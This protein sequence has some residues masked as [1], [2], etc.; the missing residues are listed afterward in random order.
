MKN[1]LFVLLLV[2][3]VSAASL[4]AQEGDVVIVEEELKLTSDDEYVSPLDIVLDGDSTTSNNWFRWRSKIGIDLTPNIWIY[5]LPF[6]ANLAA[7]YLGLSAM[8]EEPLSSA[9]SDAGVDGALKDVKLGIKAKPGSF[10][11]K[12]N[13]D[14]VVTPWLAIALDVGFATGGASINI[15]TGVDV[16]E[17][18]KGVL[19]DQLLESL[20]DSNA[21]LDVEDLNELWNPENQTDLDN[22]WDSYISDAS[23]LTE[24]QKKELEDVGSPSEYDSFDEFYDAV[25][26]TDAFQE[27]LKNQ[28]GS[29]TAIANANINMI[30]D[31]DSGD[32]DLMDQLLSAALDGDLDDINISLDLSYTLFEASLGAKFFPKKKAPY[33]FYLMPKIGFTY[34][35]VGVNYSTDT[36]IMKDYVNDML[37]EQGL[38]LPL[39]GSAWGLYTSLEMGWQVQ[40]GKNLTKDWPV[41]FGLDIVLLDVGYYVIPWAT[42]ILAH[43]MVS[44]MIG[45]DLLSN[46]GWAANIRF[47]FMPKLAFTIS[48]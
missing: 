29:S 12:L 26:E 1:R 37:V 25:Y 45:D 11:V 30:T 38:D 21:G 20:L 8:V 35:H 43:E 36:D 47:A 18:M 40:L 6:G 15:N 46:Y 3:F 10:G 9:L 17:A 41:H 24:A 7:N 27:Y 23:D 39:E 19:K 5:G 42:G 34:A 13:Y 28:Y 31:G 32:D 16:K 22:E 4:Y 33:G 14:F 44:N 48:F 2:L